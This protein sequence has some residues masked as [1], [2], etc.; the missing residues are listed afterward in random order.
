MGL[1]DIGN[2]VCLPFDEIEPGIETDAQIG[3]AHV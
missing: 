1:S 3:R 2:L